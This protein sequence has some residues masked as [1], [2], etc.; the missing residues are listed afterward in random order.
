MR[1]SIFLAVVASQLA[2]AEPVK[3]IFN[4]FTNKPDYITKI[5]SSTIQGGS[6]ISVTSFSS[7]AVIINGSGG[8]FIN[9]QSN[10][11]AGAVF[12]VASGTVAGN[13]YVSTLTTNTGA[14]VKSLPAAAMNTPALLNVYKNDASVAGGNYLLNVGSVQ[15]I[16]QFVIRDQMP[17]EFETYGLV[18]GGL[19]LGIGGFVNK[20]MSVLSIDQH[21]NFWNNGD[22]I[23]QSG[24]SGDGGKDIILKPQTIEAMRISNTSGITAISSMTVTAPGGVIVKYGVVIGSLTVNTG[25]SANQTVCWKSATTLGYCTS[26]VGSGGDCTCN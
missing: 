18:S 8:S 12:N 1:W 7:G 11:Q 21:I 4:P 19:Y 9:N 6:G 22:L 10:L 16:D 13:L 20:A 14:I 15:Q 5:D 17:V 2:F 3:T 26:V 24:L 25:G 23:I